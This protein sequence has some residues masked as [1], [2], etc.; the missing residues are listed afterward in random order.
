MKRFRDLRLRWRL[1]IAFAACAVIAVA[2]VAVAIVSLNKIHSSLAETARQVSSNIETQNVQSQHIVALRKLVVRIGYCDDEDELDD[3]EEDLDALKQ[4]WTDAEVKPL[5]RDIQDDYLAHRLDY[6][7]AL[8]D[9]ETAKEQIR[10][11]RGA[12]HALCKDISELQKASQL[13]LGAMSRDA[14]AI[15]DSVESD[16]IL[17]IENAA[18]QIRGRTDQ[19]AGELTSGF[20]KM[21]ETTAGVLAAVRNAMSV[22]ACCHEL[23]ALTKDVLLATDEAVIDNCH[24]QIMDAV[25]R[26]GTGLEALGQREETA[27]VST[28]LQALSQSVADLVGKRKRMVA[29]QAGRGS[30]LPAA[31]PATEPEA[32]A[33]GAA[34]KVGARQPRVASTDA[35]QLALRNG[36]D[37]A[38]KEIQE[39]LAGISGAAASVVDSVE[40]DAATRMQDATSANQ[41]NSAKSSQRLAGDLA[42]M[43]EQATKA[44]TSVKNA[45]AVRAAC[46]KLNAVVNLGLL[47]GDEAAVDLY[48]GEA[49]S[50][51]QSCRRM[52][53]E[54]PGSDQ[55]GAMAAALSELRGLTARMLAKRRDMLL[56]E[57]RVEQ[58]EQQVTSTSARMS[59][60]ESEIQETAERVLE[61][62]AEIEGDALKSAREMKQDAE[63]AMEEGGTLVSQRRRW[64]IGLGLLAL[65]FSILVAMVFSGSLARSL[66]SAVD[67]AGAIRSGDLSQR[68]ESS[69][70]DEIGQ[71]TLSLNAMAETLQRN[72]TQIRR[73]VSSLRDVLG[74]V[75]TASD[76]VA[77]GSKQLSDS[78]QSLSQGAT[79]QASS[80]EQIAS[81]TT[82]IGAQTKTNAQ[83]AARANELSASCR[84]L[85]AGGNEQMQSML[86]AMAEINNASERI[87]KIIKVIDDIAFQTNLLALNA[88]VEAA[89]AGRHGKGFA[90]VAEEVRSL[91][92]RSAKA[93]HETEELISSSAEKVANGMSIAE[94]SAQ[95]LA[96]IVG[97]ATEVSELVRE[98]ATACDEQARGIAQV[99]QGLEQIDGVTQQNMANAEQTASASEQLAGQASGLRRII[100][101][102]EADAAQPKLSAGRR[103]KALPRSAETAQE[104]N[105]GGPK[106]E[107][108]KEPAR[109]LT[110]SAR[111]IRPE[112]VI[113][114]DDK[115]F[116]RY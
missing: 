15:G 13:L 88:A 97:S 103:P 48:G 44:L 69:S 47:A 6:V 30:A 65:L 3:A 76:Q 99:S 16:S 95:S 29:L 27:G 10:K 32:H 4:R 78:S 115:E 8:A 49:T 23:N 86:Q 109:P 5:L 25:S 1:L 100:E 92:G 62:L 9:S 83:N 101:E 26:A 45:L 61:G 98:I 66:T 71:L 42:S 41:E 12:L 28:L 114:L 38:Q 56:A 91:A 50:L 93:A 18:E 72:D 105:A 46:E 51:L 104:G 80:L 35:E 110:G 11:D 17:A 75:S 64:L 79:E 57:K 33:E 116:G 107:A 70:R 73:N 63:T 39:Y 74:R 53:A 87:S 54:L 21:S 67:L 89:R 90:V 77:N 2:A 58:A 112:D 59:D 19:T 24:G 102:F 36:L 37:A 7:E 94:Q 106:V 60:A 52:L 84:D 96:D 22:R 113:A 20:D 85:A 55:K 82:Q 31:Q 68:L 108:D 14:T 43:S 111:V 34:P 40:L 81:A